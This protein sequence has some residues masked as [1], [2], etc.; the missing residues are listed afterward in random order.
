MS[1]YYFQVQPSVNYQQKSLQRYINKQEADARDLL[2]DTPLMR[3][4]VL[5]TESLREFKSVGDKPYGV[6]LFAETLSEQQ[7]LLFWNNQKIVPP[8]AD[9]NLP[10][11]EYFKDL[12]NGSFVVIKTRLIFPDMSNNIIAHV[13][14]PVKSQYYL[15]TDYLVDEFVHDEDASKKVE[16]SLKETEY[17]IQSESGKTLFYLQRKSHTNLAVTDTLTIVLR[18]AALIFLLVFIHLTGEAIVYKSRGLYGVIFFSGAM[19]LVRYLLFKFGNL[20]SFRHPKSMMTATISNQPKE[21]TT[22]LILSMN[23][24]SD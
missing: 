1:A 8:S 20:F 7:D 4:L 17:P 16:I 13:M 22:V 3:K 2:R 14:I 9:F 12:V 21:L 10:D 15:E 6:F 18:I 19:I 23:F 24:E 11:G 5:N